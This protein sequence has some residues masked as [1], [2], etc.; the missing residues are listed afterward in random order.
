MEELEEG[1][2]FIWDKCLHDQMFVFQESDVDRILDIIITKMTPSRSPTQK[3]VPANLLFLAARYAH[4]H[5]SSDLLEILLSTAL[6]KV[7]DVVETHQWD[8]TMLSFWI[9]NL[10]LLLHY[11]RK[12]AGTV[13]ATVTFQAGIS[14]L[15][16]ET[17]ILIIRDAER[18]MD[19]TLDKAMLDYESIPGFE[20]VTFQNEWKI[21]RSKPKAKAPEPL[22]K[23]L[24]P[25]S[26]KR[27]AQVS[28]RNITSLLSST[29]FVLELYDIHSVIVSQV[30]S[31]LFYWLGAELFNRI[32]NNR[33]YL[34]RTKAMQ[35]RMNLS[36][37]EDWARSNNRQAEHYEHGSMVSSGENTVDAARRHLEPVL[38]LLQWLQCSSSLGEDFESL[39]STLQQMPRLNTTQLIHAVKY[40]RAEVGEKALSKSAMKY[41]KALQEEVAER[42]AQSK[43]SRRLS[44]QGGDATSI[45]A[46]PPRKEA[47]NEL[48]VS[49]SSPAPPSPAEEQGDSD[50][51]D[52]LFLD[53]SLML[54]FALPSSTDMRV[55]YGGGFG[56]LNKE[57]E[58]KYIPTVPPEFLAKFDTS[59]GTKKSS[60]Y[61]QWEGDD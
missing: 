26:P 12:D 2:E 15:I 35:I 57:R 16:N 31:Q 32:L 51:P 13:D 36:T 49:P 17:F 1:Q 5:A 21:F 24:R 44:H 28:P 37:L 4:Y 10:T 58:R 48:H 47:P 33:K 20:D 50:A 29:L 8:M 39:I 23:R 55:S 60:L 53:P 22:E 27:K 34:A 3:P 18:R 52:N 38:Q 43:A 19:R 42:K 7:N 61:D 54:P 14:E 25:P 30:L 56:G 6:A 41:M 45:P 11:L 9:S 46:T 40:Y 59:N